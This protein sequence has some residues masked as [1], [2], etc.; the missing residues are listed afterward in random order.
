MYWDIMS[1]IMFM[2]RRKVLDLAV[3][4]HRPTSITN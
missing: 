3:D 1:L 4:I 2:G